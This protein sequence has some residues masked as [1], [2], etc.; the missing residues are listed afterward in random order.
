MEISPEIMDVALRIRE[1]C[2][3][4]SIFLYNRREG[5][6]GATTAFKLCLVV[7]TEDKAALERTIYLEV[8]SEVPFDV[9]LYTPEEWEI[10]SKDTAAFAC[11]IKETGVVLL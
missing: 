6:R 3:P 1:L 5:L 10:C 11:K 7:E 2:G 4:Q 8:D 9:L